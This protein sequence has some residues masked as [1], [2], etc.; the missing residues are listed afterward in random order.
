MGHGMMNAG[1]PTVRMADSRLIVLRARAAEWDRCL[2]WLDGPEPEHFPLEIIP[3]TPRPL[4][5]L[6]PEPESSLIA[7]LDAPSQCRALA[8]LAEQLRRSLRQP[9]RAAAA[10]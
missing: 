2:E 6:E 8:Y 7:E 1:S 9:A 3:P 4:D 5:D 10:G